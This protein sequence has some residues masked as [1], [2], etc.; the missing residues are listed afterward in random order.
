MS[1]TVSIAR[2]FSGP[3]SYGNGGYAAGLIARQL[4]VPVTVRL[5][6]PLPLETELV[7]AESASGWEVRA[8][9]SL[10][11]TARASEPAQPTL[12]EAPS[13][14]RALACARESLALGSPRF[15]GCF[16]CGEARAQ[17]DG[18]RIFSGALAPGQVA[19]PWT[20]SADLADAHGHVASEFVWA[21]LDCPGYFA[22][23]QDRSYALLGELAV[24]VEGRVEA[25]TPHVIVGWSMAQQGRKR[26][27]GTALFDAAGSCLAHGLAT[28]IQVDA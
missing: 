8:G 7:I 21:A 23:F 25:G 1:T 28:W 9:D 15:S 19:A 27:A 24:R 10:I 20:P 22:S 17:G 3:P 2:R 14:A 11:A 12:P 18:L 6:R 5:A 4:A 13:Q 26:V 16:V